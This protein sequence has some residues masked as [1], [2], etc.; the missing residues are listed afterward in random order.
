[1]SSFVIFMV[2]GTIET[3]SIFALIFCSFWFPYREYLKEIT[4]MAVLVTLCSYLLRVQ[5]QV[6]MAI[7]AAAAFVM[8]ILFLRYMIK[9]RFWRSVLISLMYFGFAIINSATFLLLTTL[10]IVDSS[11]VINNSSSLSAYVV[12]FVSSMIVFLL[13]YIIKKK[14]IGLSFI[15]RPPHDLMVRKVMNKDEVRIIT[16][17]LLA[18]LILFLGVYGF[19][20]EKTF[21]ALPIVIVMY[22]ILLYLAYKRDNES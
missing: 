4:L 2:L 3:H 5:L 14:N 1:M 13:A 15:L 6:N 10:R 8:L 18:S 11:E 12:Q 16:G 20:N 9:V 22:V 17:V 19:T 7:D 21:I